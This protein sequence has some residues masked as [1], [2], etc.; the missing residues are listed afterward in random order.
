[1][2]AELP[3]T[4]DTPDSR[5][6]IP[7]SKIQTLLV[8]Q[9]NMN[10]VNKLQTHRTENIN[11]RTEIDKRMRTPDTVDTPTMDV[12]T[13][14]TPDTPEYD[15]NV[16]TTKSTP[17]STGFQFS[18][19]D[20]PSYTEVDN[21]KLRPIHFIANPFSNVTEET[22]A[23]SVRWK[24]YNKNTSR[25][26]IHGARMHD[27]IEAKT[28][29]EDA[30]NKNMIGEEAQISLDKE[31]AKLFKNS[32]FDNT[33]LDYFFSQYN[34]KSFLPKLVSRKKTKI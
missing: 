20:D 25:I 26:T 16:N 29:E 23:V 10:N 34:K 30:E 8:E 17:D 13:P 32:T 9:K 4:A 12:D 1:M 14:N 2:N 28:Q 3:D 7:K 21:G 19:D 24:P 31:N 22:G 27:E 18:G 15:I 11:K 33:M 5:T 6:K